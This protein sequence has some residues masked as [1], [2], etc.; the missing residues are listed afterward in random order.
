MT[1]RELFRRHRALIL[2][3]A[4]LVPCLWF[5]TLDPALAQGVT[6]NELLPDQ[7]GQEIGTG[8]TDV[9]VTIARIIR[10]AFGLLGTVALLLILYA[11]FLW[12]TAGGDEDKVSAAKKT[13]TSAVIGLVIMLS[14]FAITS[15]VLNALIGATTGGPGGGGPG[16]G[17]PGGGIPGGGSGGAFRPTAIQPGGSL[18]KYD[19]FAAVT[20]SAAPTGD[21]ANIRSNLRL[22]KVQGS[23]RTAVEYEPVVENNAIRLRPPTPCPAPNEDRR[24]LDPDSDYVITVS[25]GLRNAS[26]S[27]TITCGLGATC[28]RSFR[29]G[30]AVFTEPPTVAIS[31]PTDGQSVPAGE[32][33]PMQAVVTD[34]NGVATVEYSADGAF[35]TADGNAQQIAPQTYSSQALLDTAAYTPVRSLTLRARAINI[36]GDMATSA[37]VRVTVRPPHCFNGVRDGDET[38]VDCGGSCG[39]CT[40]GGCTDNS[41]CASGQCVA[42]QCVESPQIADIQLRDGRPGNLVT[43]TGARFGGSPGKVTFLGT[44][45]PGDDREADL[46]AC[47]DSWSTGRIV[48][49]VPAGAVSGPISVMT[50]GNRT[51]ATNDAYGPIIPDFQVN[52]QARPGICGVTPVSAKAGQSLAVTGRAFGATQ[53]G[54]RVQFARGG[55]D[56]SQIQDWS[57][58]AEAAQVSPWGETSIGPVIPNVQTASA[59]ANYLLRVVVGGQPSNTACIR[60]E[61]PEAGTEPRIDFLTPEDGSVG[62]YL[63]VFGANFGSGGTVRFRNASG[64]AVGDISFPAQCAAGYWTGA[65]VTVKVPSRFTTPAGTAMGLGA[66]DVTVV[67][68]DGRASNAVAFTLNTDPVPPGICRVEPDNGP[69]GTPVTVHGDGFGEFVPPYLGQMLTQHPDAL[70]FHDGVN[71]TGVTQWRASSI[72][73]TVPEGATT[74]PVRVRTFQGTTTLDSNGANFLVRDCRET[75]GDAACGT[76]RSCCGDGACRASCGASVAPGGFAWQFSTGPVPVFPVVMENAT[77][78][79]SPPT[80]M[81]SPNPF[82]GASGVCTD[83][84]AMTVRFSLP[85]DPATINTNNVTL[86]ACGTGAAVGTTC[87]PVAG[88]GAPQALS[89]D[90]EGRTMLTLPIGGLQAGTWFRLTVRD[91]V[92]SLGTPERAAQQLDGDFDARGGGAYVTTFKTGEGPCALAGVDVQPADALISGADET[93]AYAAFPLSQSCIILS[94]DGRTVSWSSSDA[95][96]ATVAGLGGSRSCEAVVTPVSETDPGP[97][98]QIRSTVDGLSDAGSLRIDYANPRVTDYG[99]RQCDQACVNTVAF[100]HFNT[101]MRV[102]GAG[103]LLSNVRMYRCRNESCLAFEGE[104]P[105]SPDYNAASR[106][107]TFGN[108]QLAPETYYRVVVLGTALSTS[109]APLTGLNF[110]NDSFSWTFRTRQAANPCGPQKVTIEPAQTTLRYIGDVADVTALPRSSPDACAA[111][112]QILSSETYSWDWTKA[113]TPADPAALR[114]L[115]DV[116]PG[117]LLNTNPSLPAGC[118]T[119]CVMTGSRPPGTPRCGNGTVERGEACDTPNL[120]GCNASCLRSGNTAA[121]GCGDGAIQAERG[122][123][124]DAAAQNGAAGSGCTASCLLSGSSAGLS[125]C[126]NGSVGVGEACD[127]G[128]TAAGDGCGPTCTLEGSS[129]D[130]FVCGNGQL[131][132]GEQCDYELGAT[133]L[134]TRLLIPGRAAIPLGASD[135]QNPSRPGF[136]CTPSCLLRGNPVRGASAAGACGNGLIEP[137]KGEGCDAG[138]ANGDPASGCSTSCLKTGSNPDLRAFCGDTVVTVKPSDAATGIQNGGGEECEALALDANVDATQ[139]LE[140]LNQCDA[141]NSC[142]ASVRA[143]VGTVSGQGSVSVE[144]SCRNDGDCAAFG[145]SGL[146][147]GAGACCYRR[148]D[149]PQIQP[150]GGNQCRNA[151]VTVTFPERMDLGSLQGGLIVESCSG[152]VV[153]AEGRS[154]LARAALAVGGFFRSLVGLP[155][156]AQAACSPIEGTFQ[157]VAGTGPGGP[158]TISKFVPKQ[159]FDAN[160][161]YRV[162]VRSGANGVKTANGVGYPEGQNGLS[163]GFSTGADV[164]DFDL[165]DLTPD[166]ELLQSSSIVLS[167]AATAK[168]NRN[169]RLESIAPIAGVY[170]WTWGWSTVPEATPPGAILRLTGGTAPSATV[171]ANSGQNGREQVLAVARITADTILT[172]ST[173]NKEK[174]GVSTITVMLCERPWPAR[175]TLTGA[176]AP[177]VDPATHFEFSYCRDNSGGALPE[178]LPG[179]VQGQSGSAGGILRFCE[180]TLDAGQP[181]SCFSDADCSVAADRC[182]S[183]DLFFRFGQDWKISDAIGMR[184]YANPDRLTP[185]EWFE[186]QRFTGRTQATTVDGYAAIQ[187]ERTT[188]VGAVDKYGDPELRPYVY[189]FS[190]NEGADPRTAEVFNR[191]V[192]NVRFNTNLVPG[193]RAVNICKL[194][195][196]SIARTAPNAA[197]TACSSDLDCLAAFGT[198][199]PAGLTCDADKDK[200]RRDMR[201]WQDMRGIEAA[202]EGIRARTGSY[203]QLQSGSFI[204]GFSTSKWP[205]W[206]TQLGDAGRLVD[207]L[208]RF[209]RCEKFG[210][211]CTISRRA[212]STNAECTGGTGDTC[213]PRFEAETCYDDRASVFACPA[214]SRVY[215]YRSI[216][217]QDYRM[218]V[219]LEYTLYPWA[220]AD[221]TAHDAEDRCEAAVGCSWNPTAD[222]CETRITTSAACAGMPGGPKKCL[223]TGVACTDSS[224]C[225]PGDA[226]VPADVPLTGPAAGAVCGNGLLEGAEACEIGATQVVACGAGLGSRREA[227]NATCTGW[228]V[229]Q[230]C[231]GAAMCG[232]GALE[233]YAGES[234]DDGAQT[235]QYGRCRSGSQYGCQ[236][237]CIRVTKRPG[238]FDGV[239]GDGN[240][241]DIG[242]T[243]TSNAQCDG[244]GYPAI[245]TDR[246]NFCGDG[247]KNGPELCDDGPDNG[248]YGHC[249]WDCRGAGPRCG[250]SAV[251]GAEM[252]DGNQQTASGV[253]IDASATL[254]DTATMS[255]TAEAC[256]R[257]ADCGTGRKCALCAVTSGGLPQ[258]RTKSCFAASAPGALACTFDSWSACRPSGACGNGRVEGAEE[259]DAGTANS[260]TG[261]CLPSCKRN[262]CNDGFV[263][264]GVEQCDNGPSNGV[265]CVPQYGLTCN[266]CDNSCSIRTLSGGFC[267]DS[268]FQNAAAT[269]P[270]PEQCDALVGLSNRTVCVSTRPEHQS[271]G[272]ITGFTACTVS[273]CQQTCADPQSR[274]CD[275]SQDE[276]NSDRYAGADEACPPGDTRCATSPYGSVCPA[277]G[278]AVSCQIAPTGDPRYDEQSPPP[279]AVVL[280]NACDPDDDNDGVPDDVDCGPTIATVHGAYRYPTDGSLINIPAAAEICDAYDNDCNGTVNDNPNLHTKVDMIFTVD[281]SGSMQPYI[282]RISEAILRFVNNYQ[283]S[284]HRFGLVV[285][286]QATGAPLQTLGPQGRVVINLTNVAAFQAAFAALQA[287]GGHIEPMYDSV[288]ELASSTNRYGIAWSDDAHPYVVVVTDEPPTCGYASGSTCTGPAD[289]QWRTEQSVFEKVRAGSC[290]VSGCAGQP[291]FKVETFVIAPSADKPAWDTILH[292]EVDR[293]FIEI[294]PAG[295]GSVDYYFGELRDKTFSNV[296]GYGQTPAGPGGGVLSQ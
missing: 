7:V 159:L 274:I 244:L 97:P 146:S 213:R 75:G 268:V 293:R 32:L 229:V 251:N 209:D 140:A 216:G 240:G 247:I 66:Y 168:T 246:M 46:A 291:G 118:S 210:S 68:A 194:A 61:P 148:P 31:S 56:C 172:P 259:C 64:E 20:F 85:M 34:E 119:A 186:A 262:V 92:R 139:V 12:M 76:G 289:A 286:G 164:C 270:G 160:R 24:C 187:S 37:P 204:R 228:N 124:C 219:G 272:R 192:Q 135:E 183:K 241:C 181:K 71:A 51:D 106:L 171:Q 157:H 96:K 166:T 185:Q 108:P 126:G 189:V 276:T 233:S 62:T 169:G 234:C 81:P 253:C 207:P 122:E 107:L 144:C 215:Q 203:P 98:I 290:E 149:P 221:C 265:S 95:A 273:S 117:T 264:A 69:V 150:V 245:C 3:L 151:L 138:P 67:R 179:P 41:S 243:C 277:G 248:T 110:R 116:P 284:Q 224:T 25:T 200:I 77:C 132:P 283:G 35:L 205:S 5:A 57:Q 2:G 111:A 55:A 134:G 163:Q 88:V 72:L 227:C 60:V 255:G 294:A 250:D 143:A 282:D 65:S 174:I 280:T 222:A 91:Q 235:G 173:V 103:S 129:Q 84:G 115:P 158:S 123:E 198:Q 165:V 249:A 54:S 133:G 1:M 190:Y 26:G 74:G 206:A 184:A 28:T 266:Y 79:V 130:A 145:V 295:A 154:W 86:E 128:N 120:N 217:G 70:R 288:Y 17:G 114:F 156:T 27:G 193:D 13:M 257:D 100:A 48:V 19:V 105:V 45:A 125:S 14:A 101:P 261:E 6:S 287:N 237:R 99:P 202:L 82:K 167:L 232:N 49:A 50:S 21:I 188:Y 109:D 223:A 275:N 102:T 90:A 42:G 231:P 230:A 16:G 211:E 208:N 155:V 195:D 271:Y 180:R 263:R 52:D 178:L 18:A 63:T 73:S 254:A 196:G 199:P 238:P 218:N 9:R 23:S 162:T 22:E 78:Q 40:G 58:A 87:S 267:G 30:D 11:G 296:C 170:D 197:P 93:K 256:S 201:R 226:C 278:P 121:N 33:V 142:T 137:A 292:G 175:D 177:Y 47:T 43:V 36:D 236:S 147:C 59:G 152:P 176:W 4:L 136:A 141:R 252:C 285:F 161:N 182:L 80:S 214:A 281:I 220:D 89:Y 38:A 44:A 39:A 127:D 242:P 153:N 8:T 191:L 15:F 260:V 212:C 29:T 53:S 94:C 225:A 112:G 269:P 131:E 113:Q 83:I 239:C 104:V 279:T 258:T 10:V